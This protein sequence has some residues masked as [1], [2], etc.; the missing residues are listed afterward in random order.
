MISS[1]FALSY[2]NAFG[3]NRAKILSFGTELKSIFSMSINLLP[4]DK[5]LGSPKLKAFADD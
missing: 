2:A 5:I 1:S 3:L 4:D